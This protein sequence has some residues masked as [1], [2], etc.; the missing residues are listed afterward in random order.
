MNRVFAWLLA[1]LGMTSSAWAQATVWPPSNYLN[2]GVT[3]RLE[4]R[5][6]WTGKVTNLQGFDWIGEFKGANGAAAVLVT[7]PVDGNDKKFVFQARSKSGNNDTYEYCEINRADKQPGAGVYSGKRSFR[8]KF[9]GALVMEGAC[10]VT[11]SIAPISQTGPLVWPPSKL[12]KTGVPIAISGGQ[13]YNGTLTTGPDADGTWKGK[14][15]NSAVGAVDLSAYLTSTPPDSEFYTLKV[16][17]TREKKIVSEYCVVEKL[18]AQ[19]APGVYAGQLLHRAD[20]AAD[21]EPYGICRVT[22]GAAQASTTSAS[23]QVGTLVWPPLKLLKEGVAVRVETRQV[24]TGNI[25]G[26]ND[27][28]DWLARMTAASGTQGILFAYLETG[29]NTYDFQVAYTTD[30][31]KKYEFC[32]FKNSASQVAPGVYAG[33]RYY[34]VGQADAKVDGKC[35]VTITIPSVEQVAPAPTPAP[36]LAPTPV[37]VLTPAP[38]PTPIGPALSWPLKI[39]IGQQWRVTIIGAKATTFTLNLT[40]PDAFGTDSG[41]VGTQ[42]VSLYLSRSQDAAAL[43][44]IPQSGTPIINCTFKGSTSV[45]GSSLVRGTVTS[46]ANATALPVTEVG[47]CEVA[48]I[49]DAPVVAQPQPQSQPQVAPVTPAPPTPAPPTPTPPTPTPPTPAP[50]TPTPVTL[51]GAAPNTSVWPVRLEVGQS[52]ATEIQGVG[53]WNVDFKAL[54]RDGDPTGAATPAKGGAAL[55][56]YF[57]YVG[58]D[59]DVRLEL[60]SE[61]NLS[62]L[63]IFERS[64]IRGQTFSGYLYVPSGPDN[65]QKTTQRCTMKYLGRVGAAAVSAPNIKVWP[66]KLS[67]GQNWQIDVQGFG[68]WKIVFDALNDDQ[69][70]T[71]TAKPSATGA[72]LSAVF[73]YV[74]NNDDVRLLLSENGALKYRCIF[75]QSDITSLTFK[76]WL[77]VPS[78]GDNLQKTTQ[79]CTMRYLGA[80]TLSALLEPLTGLVSR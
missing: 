7:Y 56:S 15:T 60:V 10:R 28:G 63:C 30:S 57:Y 62:Y 42:T 20:S 74:D 14:A 27:D 22:I 3:V 23:S 13:T 68:S 55:E 43:E 52:W 49:G 26:K 5:Q 33:T 1:F 35:K 47:A 73:T 65:L 21:F 78:G 58:K 24:W 79:S 66:L 40:Q 76:G 61:N 9:G 11:V 64:E 45:S 51:G 70:P 46:R 17:Y 34:K 67:V 39:S 44:I 53:A 8:A 69:D 48:L 18:A 31:V 71:G 6:V 32:S 37:P 41:T 59:D 2:V 77:Y 4:T 12:F 25:E 36:P 29:D 72:T 50:V 75:E 38:V 54:D 80:V 16:T 19:I